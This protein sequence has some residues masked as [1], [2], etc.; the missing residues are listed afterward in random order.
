MGM[1]WP[2]GISRN[3]WSGLCQELG[4]F[5]IQGLPVRSPVLLSGVALPALRVF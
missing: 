2:E 5:D 4:F 1:G 3:E